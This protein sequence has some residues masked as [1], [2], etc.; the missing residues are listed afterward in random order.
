MIF[1]MGI[2]R[3]MSKWVCGRGKVHLR[4]TKEREGTT[5][6]ERTRGR[7]NEKF[8]RKRAFLLCIDRTSNDLLLIEPK[9][10]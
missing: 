4:E 5:E 3:I 10:N 1:L 9:I 2:V 7:G 6:K 8:F